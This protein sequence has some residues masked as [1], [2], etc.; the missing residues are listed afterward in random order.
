MYNSFQVKL[1]K[2]FSSGL[3]AGANY[4]LARLETDASSTT[5]SVAGYGGIGNVINP[6]QGRRNYT[7]SPDDITHTFS[8]LGV[9]DL[10][11]GHKRRWLNSS[12]LFDV[13]LGNWTL[14]SSVKL[15]SGMPLYF[16]NSTTCG[17]PSQFQAECL[18][19][20]LNPGQVLAQ[21]WGS[22]D[23]NRPMY[24]AAAFEPAS[25]FASGNYLGIGP[26]VSS[27]RG[28]PYRD[29]NI[30]LSKQFDFTER[31]HFELRAE[32]FNVFNNHYFTCDG[33]AFG[34]C[35]PFN[36]DPSSANFGTWNGVV[37]Q[38]RNIQLVGRITFSATGYG[39]L[40]GGGQMTPPRP[41]GFPDLGRLRCDR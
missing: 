20:I 38:P 29:T 21:H 33:Q 19:G 4:T 31:F 10:P 5:Q 23:V 39:G 41:T 3:Y 6:L 15:T 34:D 30:S 12:G 16:R 14:S 7:L 2:Q 1:E 35:I 36:N 37:S 18:P 28:S 22:V 27:V 11:F 40:S 26:R 8:L 17:V 32:T 24:N 25:M 9:Y 13:L